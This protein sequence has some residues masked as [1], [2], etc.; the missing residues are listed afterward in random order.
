MLLY[1][2]AYHPKSFLLVLNDDDNDN[3]N[4]PSLSLGAGGA[5]VKVKDWPDLKKKK[6]R[7]I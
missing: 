4:I 6:K 2:T 7:L 1:R 5:A 3:N